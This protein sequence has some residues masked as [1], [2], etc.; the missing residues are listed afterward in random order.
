[1]ADCWRC[2]KRHELTS[3]RAAVKRFEN[4]PDHQKFRKLA[5]VEH[6]RRLDM[7]KENKVLRAEL[8]ELKLKS[9]STEEKLERR[10]RK[11]KH[12]E[13][14]LKSRDRK[15][16]EQMEL[17]RQRD[18]QI[19]EL[20]KEKEVLLQPFRDALEEIR[21][22]RKSPGD[23][24]KGAYDEDNKSN[25]DSI[26]EE[27][28]DLLKEIVDLRENLKAKEAQEHCTSIPKTKDIKQSGNLY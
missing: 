20:N 5:E 12:Q 3:L 25:S 13:D 1:M 16:S 19:G 27:V 7:E 24:Q 2:P 9:R 17:I 11:I 23:E 26:P 28:T 8:A 10:D 6:T 22:N 4:D 14:L 18:R 21:A 15:I